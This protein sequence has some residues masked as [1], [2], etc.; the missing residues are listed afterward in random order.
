MDLAFASNET[1]ATLQCIVN[2]I[3]RL[4]VNLVIK[5]SHPLDAIVNISQKMIAFDPQL[6]SSA[7]QYSCLASINI[8]D[9]NFIIQNTSTF[10]FTLQGKY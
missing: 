2:T 3:D 8:D 4:I 1:S 9:I 5:W 6:T 10:N 7:G